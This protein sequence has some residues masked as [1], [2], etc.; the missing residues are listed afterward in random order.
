MLF[1][2]QSILYQWK[3]GDRL[4]PELLVYRY[5]NIIHRPFVATWV[6]LQVS[7]MESVVEKVTL[8]QVSSEYLVSPANSH[9][10]K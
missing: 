1:P 7:H 8:E 10:T 2:S 4:F 6:Q 3:V 5:Q 9:S